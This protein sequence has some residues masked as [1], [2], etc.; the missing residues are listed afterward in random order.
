M[1]QVDYVSDFFFYILCTCVCV[2]HTCLIVV[3]GLVG[4]IFLFTLCESC[5]SNSGYRAWQ[6]VP[7][8]SKPSHWAWV[9]F[10]CLFLLLCYRVSRIPG[11]PGAPYTA[12][13]DLEL[14]LLLPLPLE[15]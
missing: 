3:R 4:V 11:W 10:V 14:L 5:N 6:K 1:A 7:L 13:D 12:A 9:L 15:S 2:G 8:P